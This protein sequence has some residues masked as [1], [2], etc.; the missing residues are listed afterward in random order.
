MRYA[1]A[2][3]SFPVREACSVGI[4]FG[5]AVIISLES[6]ASVIS[7]SV[8]FLRAA[9][10]RGL[11]ERGGKSGGAVGTGLLLPRTIFVPFGLWHTGYHLNW[12]H[13]EIGLNSV[14][15]VN[16]SLDDISTVPSDFL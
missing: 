5:L 12:I 14:C 1:H 15:S 16:P 10:L 2:C 13:F 8:T 9:L 7:D 4:L 3:F 11:F 6:A